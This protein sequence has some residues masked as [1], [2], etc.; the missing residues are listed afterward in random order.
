MQLHMNSE[1]IEV[2]SR[3]EAFE[4]ARTFGAD[5]F[6]LTYWHPIIRREKREHYQ[7]IGK[8]WFATGEH[9]RDREPVRVVASG[10]RAGHIMRDPTTN[11]TIQPPSDA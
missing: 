8:H 1:S 4:Y 2:E 3:A 11:A 5:T 10:K 9:E 6:E 7:R